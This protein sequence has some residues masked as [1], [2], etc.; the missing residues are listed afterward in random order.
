MCEHKPSWVGP[1]CS[2]DAQVVNEDNE[3]V[4]DLC[5]Y[6]QHRYCDICNEFWTSR[7][8]VEK[9]WE[10]GYSYGDLPQ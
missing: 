8:D 7:I 4:E 10:L 1:W 5:E 9:V 3:I 2:Y 6:R